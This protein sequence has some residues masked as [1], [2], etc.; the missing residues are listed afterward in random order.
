MKTVNDYIKQLQET[1]AEWVE[2]QIGAPVKV[3]ID[4]SRRVVIFKGS[5]AAR[6]VKIKDILE[7]ANK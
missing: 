1:N 2:K 7:V 5:Y 3:T 4:W 6:E